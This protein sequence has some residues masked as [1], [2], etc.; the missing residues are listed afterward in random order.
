MHYSCFNK[1]D[2]QW[3]A[4]KKLKLLNHSAVAFQSIQEKRLD[5]ILILSDLIMLPTFQLLG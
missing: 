3:G 4:K 1:P 5:Q 2:V